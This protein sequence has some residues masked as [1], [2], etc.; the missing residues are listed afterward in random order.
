[1][2]TR[3]VQSKKSSRKEKQRKKRIIFTWIFSVIV[4]IF[5]ILFFWLIQ[6]PQLQIKDITLSG[7]ETMSPDS[8]INVVRQNISGKKMWLFPNASVIFYPK[9]KIL[10]DIFSFDYR[11][12]NVSIDVDTKR[13]LKINIEEYKPKFVW[14]YSD[15]CYFTDEWGYVFQKIDFKPRGLYTVF[16]NGI[17]KNSALGSVWAKENL[18][19][20]KDF[21]EF[22]KNE[23]IPIAEVAYIGNVDYYFYAENGTEI[24]IDF[25]SSIETAQSY[26]HTFIVQNSD[27]I[28]N[29][30]YEYID[31]RFGKKIFYKDKTVENPASL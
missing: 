13:V 10:N 23:N 27:F 6:K 9:D 21:I 1:M 17:E 18:R 16:R 4:L 14:C 22:F 25:D 31:A 30:T 5:V 20:V 26:L 12:K 11:I 15:D 24:R 28:K 8:I 19:D 3:I 7:A 29:G 2:D